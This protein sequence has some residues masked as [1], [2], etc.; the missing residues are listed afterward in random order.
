MHL[1]FDVIILVGAQTAPSLDSGTF[2]SSVPKSF[3]HKPKLEAFDNSL[4][5]WY[6]KMG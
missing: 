6:D 3:G 1:H 4:I 2:F 5:F